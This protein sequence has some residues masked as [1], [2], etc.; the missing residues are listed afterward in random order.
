VAPSNPDIMLGTGIYNYFAAA[1]PERFPIVKP[2]LLFLPTGD[3]KL[4]I[5]LLTASSQRARYASI[6]AKV[7]LMQ[8]Y[9]TFE[10]NNFEAIKIAEELNLKY[11]NNPYFKKYYARLLVSTGKFAEFEKY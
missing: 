5:M 1:I 6:E 11:P 10:K 9:Y 4:G 2:M 7:A 3:K 8:I